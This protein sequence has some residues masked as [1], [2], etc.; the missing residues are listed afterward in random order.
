[1]SGRP[2]RSRSTSTPRHRP[3]A[4]SGS[5]PAATSVRTQGIPLGF[6]R[7]PGEIGVYQERGDILFHHCD[8]W[9]SA[10]R[11]TAEGD[12][13][14]RRHLRGSWHAG[15]RL[16]AGHGTDDFVKNAAR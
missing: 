2:S 13:G 15:T 5:F 16:D 11:A 10:A 1:M 14:V 12:A 9:H 4:S 6:E 3:T 8:L 7:V